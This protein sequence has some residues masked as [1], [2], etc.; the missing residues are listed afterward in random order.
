MERIIVVGAGGIGRA[1]GLI[2]LRHYKNI[3][4]IMADID[5]AQC[6]NA[7]HWIERGLGKS[8]PAIENMPISDASLNDWNPS[9]DILLDCTPGA[10]CLSV[11]KV[12]V[13]NRM[14]YANLTENVPETK[15]ILELVKG[16]SKGFVLQT[17]VA[18]GYINILTKKLIQTA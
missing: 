7:I 16:H 10:L 8:P 3:H 9:A 14:H 6:E 11:A 5:A 12:A 18:P 2:L 15:K 13:R 1:C 17:G 4:L